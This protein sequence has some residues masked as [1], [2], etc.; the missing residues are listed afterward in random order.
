M[1]MP[2][3]VTSSN[4]PFSKVRTSSGFSN[5]FSTVSSITTTPLAGLTDNRSNGF[6]LEVHC[7]WERKEGVKQGGRWSRRRESNPH[8]AKLRQILSLLRLPVPPLRACLQ[9]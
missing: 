2:P 6:Y 1:V 5:R 4:L 8:G 9:N 7:K 3:I